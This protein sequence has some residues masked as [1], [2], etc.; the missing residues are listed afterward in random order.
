[1]TVAVSRTAYEAALSPGS[2]SVPDESG[3]PAPTFRSWGR[4]AQAVYVLSEEV[5]AE[6]VSHL[7]EVADGFDY[8]DDYTRAEGRACR[9]AAAHLRNAARLEG[10]V[11]A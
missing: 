1:M 4:G 7:E 9:L 10:R 2:S 8:G 11:G 6:M 3:W 5:A